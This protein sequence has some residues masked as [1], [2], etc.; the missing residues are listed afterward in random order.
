MYIRNVKP[1]D[2]SSLAELHVAAWQV[3]YRQIL[4]DALLDNLSV[5]QA[6]TRWTHLIRDGQRSTLVAEVD[7]RPI[8]FVGF[9]AS[10]DQDDNPDLVGEIYAAYVHP[11]HWG[12]G[13]GTTLLQRAI[14]DLRDQGFTEITVWTLTQN[15][16]ARR[17]YEKM[18]FL[19]DGATKSIERRG[20]RFDEV[21]YRRRI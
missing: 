4:P 14:A 15:S 3:A 16:Q 20:A 9:G 7:G 1:A 19:A 18:G 6:Q 13:A 8:G 2:I 21:R 17:F 11:A 12:Q 10:R 5:D